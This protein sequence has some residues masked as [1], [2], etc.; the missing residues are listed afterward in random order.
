MK[1]L[2][3]KKRTNRGDEDSTEIEYLR[4]IK[5]S[6]KDSFSISFGFG[7]ERKND[8]RELSNQRRDRDLMNS[9]T[10]NQSHNDNEKIGLLYSKMKDF[11][12]GRKHKEMKVSNKRLI[13]IVLN[14]LKLDYG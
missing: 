10:F 9:L 8:S 12:F 14:I 5:F 13:G 11:V 2:L 7:H 3:Q 1:S 4:K 6:K